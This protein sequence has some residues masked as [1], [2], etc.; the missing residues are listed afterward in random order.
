MSVHDH[1]EHPRLLLTPE[2]AAHALSIGRTTVYELMLSG[3]L[4]SVKIGASRRVPIQAVQ[5]YVATLTDDD[6][7]GPPVKPTERERCPDRPRTAH[8][9]HIDPRIEPAHG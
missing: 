4:A 2:Q 3:A 1:S 8:T 7:W 6:F 9:A 5:D